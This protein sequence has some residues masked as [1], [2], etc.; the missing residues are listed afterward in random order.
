[1]QGG[2]AR[3]RTLRGRL[4]TVE[5]LSPAVFTP[6]RA[7]EEAS[8]RFCQNRCLLMS[9]QQFTRICCS[10]EMG[11]SGRGMRGSLGLPGQGSLHSSG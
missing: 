11:A 4:Q 3:H 10:I 1:M 2:P 9:T 6:K 8:A 7:G 5:A